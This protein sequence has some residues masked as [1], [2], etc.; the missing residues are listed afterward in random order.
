[1]A[2]KARGGIEGG[3]LWLLLA[4]GVTVMVAIILATD[5]GVEG[6]RLAVRATAR[7]SFAMFM[8]AFTASSLVR[9]WP[10]ETTRWLVRNRRWFG[11]GF[12]WSHLLHLLAILWLFGNYAGQVPAPPMATIV[13]GGI[14]YV[15]IAAM[16]ATS[17]DGAV[18]WMGA[19]NW[20]RLHKTGVWYVWIVFMTSYGKRA[21]VMPE[22]I[23]PVLLL[24]AAAALR[25]SWKRARTPA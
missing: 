23:P 25:F 7:T 9:L 19:K 22:Y 14:A 24:I 13:G 2:T 16:A 8:I 10:G 3:R 12:A 5:S 1:M 15:F 4:A 17:F 21:L 11:L 18:R 20:Q 6:I